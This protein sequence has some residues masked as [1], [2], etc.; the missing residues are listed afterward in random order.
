MSAGR[1]VLGVLGLLCV[2]GCSTVPFREIEL[3]SVEAVDP[4]EMLGR[5]GLAL[6]VKCRVV[7]TVTFKFMGRAVTAIGYTDADTSKR[8]FTVV[9]LHPSGG[10]TLFELSGDADHVES[11]FALEEFTRR[12]D[13][14][15][16]VADDTRRIY[17]DCVP[18]PAA[19]VS[20]KNG[21]IVFRQQAAQGDIEY[22]FGGADGVLV[23]KRY[24]EKGRKVWTASYYEYRWEQ[25]KLYPA[26]IVL[27][28]H[29]YGYQL[30]VRLKEI[31]S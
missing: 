23:R 1:S 17:F 26:G 5:F 16:A 10:I 9:G 14:A 2:V 19:K 7:T 22:V 8:T 13:F 27:E 30:L 25:G 6:P 29:E 3:V 12:G 18:G 28:D 4:E 24:Y 11:A 31:R 21:R 15:Q 20:K